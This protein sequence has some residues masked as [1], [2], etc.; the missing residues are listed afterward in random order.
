MEIL[1]FQPVMAQMH[2]HIPV[3]IG[4]ELIAEVPRLNLRLKISLLGME[5]GQFLITKLFPQDLVGTFRN[6][7]IRD[8]DMRMSFLHG[9]TVYGFET[10]VLNVVTHPT[11]MFFLAYPK[12]I[13][14]LRT[15]TNTRYECILPAVSMVGNEIVSMVIVDISKHGCQGIIRTSP[16]KDGPSP[17]LF[18]V[19]KRLD[20]KVQF[21]G[22]EYKSNITGKIRT[23]AT[24]ADKIMIG[25][26]FE[27]MGPLVGADFHNFISLVT[28]IKR[29]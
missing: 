5:K 17:R 19:D 6:E 8:S 23:I 2:P 15:R 21:P 13:E 4:S 7:A 22:N 14:E 20:L 27:A 16:G 12:K 3:P 25:I 9:D 1:E 10:Q 11:R 18:S 29:Q 24:D 28:E 26:Q